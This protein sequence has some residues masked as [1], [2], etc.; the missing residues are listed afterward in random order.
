MTKA[1]QWIR[2]E[3]TQL[4]AY[5]VPDPGN[6]IKLDA[7]ENPYEWPREMM[8]QWLQRLDGVGV[9]RY[10]DPDA[11]GV[12]ALLRKVFEIPEH[13]PLMLGNGSDEL[14]QLIAMTVAGEGRT[15]LSVEPSFAMYKIIATS[16][17]MGYQG[18]QLNDDFSLPID[19]F[20]AV[21]EETQP[22][23]V[24]LAHPNNPTGNAF[25]VADI[26]KIIAAAPGIVVIDEAY[27]AFADHSF[28][29]DVEKYDNV[30][31]MRTVSKIGL[32]GLRL[33]YMVGPEGLMEQIGK[34]RLPYNINVLTQVT[35]EFALEN[36]D[37]LQQQVDTLREER[38]K[39]F[40]QLGAIEGVTVYPSQTNFITLRT[41]AGKASE[42]FEAIKGQ[43]VLIKNLS[44]AGGLLADCLRVTVGTPDENAAFLDALGGLV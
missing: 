36:I 24:F 34:L 10:P 30:L 2:P 44:P 32:A 20:L 29:P 43:G 21:M 6:L 28:L 3:V 22:A 11:K 8:Q 16:V 18:V 9:N 23:L 14:I 19:E 35:A 4:H 40:E 27:S 33:G 26:E 17:G 15:L 1:E 13:L 42:W 31:V 12:K 41:P 39:L 5:H 37:V 7:M 38:S 25:N